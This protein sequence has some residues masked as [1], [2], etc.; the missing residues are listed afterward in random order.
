MSRKRLQLYS[1]FPNRPKPS[2]HTEPLLCVVIAEPCFTTL[3]AQTPFKPGCVY[4]LLSRAATWWKTR[5]SWRSGSSTRPTD[6][7][8]CR[9]YGCCPGSVL[10]FTPSVWCRIKCEDAS[11]PGPGEKKRTHTRARLKAKDVCFCFEAPSAL[12]GSC[13]CQNKSE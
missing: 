7:G 5:T 10:M 3:L 8:S 11:R 2:S 1:E 12:W 6:N 13:D 9:P 4:F